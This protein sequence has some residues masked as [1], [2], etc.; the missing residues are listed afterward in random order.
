MEAHKHSC[1]TCGES[2]ENYHKWVMHYRRKDNICEPYDEY[3]I[4]PIP[5]NFTSRQFHYPF[6]HG[7]CFWCGKELKGRQ[8]SYCSPDHYHQYYN[9]FDWGN[10]RSKVMRRDGH[11]CVK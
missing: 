6:Q 1:L 3:P 7:K 5:M 4:R 8:K 10:L 9:H 11:K 2:F